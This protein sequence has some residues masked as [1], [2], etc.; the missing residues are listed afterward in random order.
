[1]KNILLI[2]LIAIAATGCEKF[3]DKRDPKATTFQEF[4]NT[5]EDLRRVVY[6]SY[7][8]VFTT[9]TDRRLLFYMQDGRTDDAYSRISGDHH[10]LIANGS[11]NSNARLSEYY[12]TIHM[13]HIGRLNTYIA[14]VDIPYVDDEAVRENYRNILEGLRAWHYFIA[15]SRWGNVPFLLEPADLETAKQPAKP[16]EEILNLLFPMA[17]EIANKLPPDE[18]TTNAYMFNKYSLKALIMRYALYN[19]KYEMAARLAKEIMDSK[20][21]ELFASYANLF[22]YKGDKINKE[23]IMKMDMP[24]HNNTAT[25]SF[26][27]LGPQYRTGPGQSYSVPT[28]ALVDAYWTLQGRPIDKCPLYKKEQYELNPKLNRDPRFSASIF[29]HGDKFSGE[30]INIYDENSPLYYKNLRA[31]STGYWYKKFVDEADA[32]K[33]SGGNMHFPLLRY[34]EVLLTY[35]EAKIMLGDVDD[36]AKSC[37]NQI[38]KRAGLDMS[39]ADVT[40]TPKTKQEWID[41][42]RNERRTEFAAEGLRYD[43]IIRWKTAEVVLNKPA[44]GHTRKIDDSLVSLK[45]EDR[46]FL[47]HQ[48]LWP[49]HESSL[50][51]EPGLKQNPGY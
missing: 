28:K 50:R 44:L 2:I 31:S 10:Q 22:N 49:F 5:E 29:G 26:R 1:M 3:L 36:L 37:I 43:D 8:D 15:T 7:T 25:N 19:G 30:I 24:S 32:F 9:V 34:A 21:Y 18:Y 17:E 39:V 13:K 46:E 20:K 51:V 45:I 33:T 23:F 12:W 40:L 6:S 42:I 27:D 47:T 14:N 38:R 41:L 35:A 16:K 4:F 11:M 48:Y